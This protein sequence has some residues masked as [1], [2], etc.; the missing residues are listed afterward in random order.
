V[1]EVI[2]LDNGV[3]PDSRDQVV[4]LDQTAGPGHE[5]TESIEH[6]RAQTDST[7]VPQEPPLTG[8]EPEWSELVD[9]LH[10]V[11]HTTKKNSRKDQE[12]LKAFQGPAAA[13][14]L[15]M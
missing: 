6:L 7:P 12:P 9:T 4:L 14:I 10:W 2:L 5:D 8:L 15:E 13:L 3:R 11:Q 1:S